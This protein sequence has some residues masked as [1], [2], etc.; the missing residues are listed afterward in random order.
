MSGF[1]VSLVI[2]GVFVGFLVLRDFVVFLGFGVGVFLGLIICGLNVDCLAG[3]CV[4]C[5]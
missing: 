3:V 5:F 1:L 4:G 2:L